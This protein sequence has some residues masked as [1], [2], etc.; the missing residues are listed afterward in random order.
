[1]RANNKNKNYKV[2]LSRK[3]FDSATGGI[4]S[5]VI[6]NEFISFPIPEG[7]SGLFYKDLNFNGTRLNFF[8][9]LRQ[10]NATLYSECHMDPNLKPQLYGL[11]ENEGWSPAFGQDG[12]AAIHLTKTHKFKPGDVFLFFGRFRMA[13]RNLHKVFWTGK[14]EFHAIY[15]F[16]EIGEIINIEKSVD[17][18]FTKFKNHPH[19]RMKDSNF[20]SSESTLF[21]PAE[22]SIHGFSKTFGIFKFNNELVLSESTGS[23]NKWKLP[24]PFR[25]KSFSYLKFIPKN[26]KITSPGRGQEMVGAADQNLISWIGEI[27]SKYT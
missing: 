4:A 10:L 7:G 25:N 19:I 11:K 18:D 5:P 15:G 14:R 13:E 21:I 8:E 22:K 23:L 26:G 12:L 6:E 3:G 27:I 17:F 16:L 24:V 9:I 2:S 20:Y 1:M